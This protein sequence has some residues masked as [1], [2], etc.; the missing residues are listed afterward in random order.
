MIRF[1]SLILILIILASVLIAKPAEQNTQLVQLQ[2]FVKPDINA[3]A[4]NS[5]Q[6]IETNDTKTNSLQESGSNYE[7]TPEQ[8]IKSEPPVKEN[9]SLQKSN[10]IE[11]K[12]PAISAEVALVKYLDSN[13]SIFEFNAYKHWPIASLTKLMTAVVFIENG[14]LNKEITINKDILETEGEAGNFKIGEIFK[15]EDLIKAMLIVS[16]ND[17]AVALAKTKGFSFIGLMNQKAKE[18]NMN[19]TN[20]DDPTGLSFLNQ[21]RVSDLAKLVSYIYYNHPE[22]FE[23]TREKTAEIFDFNSGTKRILVN[24]NT[25]AGQPDFIGGKSG[26]TDVSNGNLISFF[27]KNNRPVLI[28]VLGSEDKF[29]DTE[30]LLKKFDY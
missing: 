17:A 10:N 12:Q 19:G 7:S 4:A 21:S 8:E 25:F 23:I 2:E 11:I 5:E 29:G 14:D 9:L 3:A 28:I 26:Y 30:R 1:Q 18:I 27:N 22:I 15:A 16:S 20:F 24:S 13:V 6:I